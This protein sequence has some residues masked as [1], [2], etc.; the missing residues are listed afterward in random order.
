MGA[1]V[2][3]ETKLVFFREGLACGAGVGPSFGNYEN[4]E[5]FIHIFEFSVNKCLRL[6]TVEYLKMI[7]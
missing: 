5:T 1:C 4:S 7:R 6:R 3:V 2:R